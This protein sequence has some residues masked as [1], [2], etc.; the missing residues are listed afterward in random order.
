MDKFELTAENYY[1]NEANKLY[2]SASQYL[3]FVGH[4]GLV[5]CEER[6]VATLNGEWE[7]PT[8]TAQLVGSYVDAYFEG[9]L[10]E[11]TSG[12]PEIFTQKGE[13]RSE[14][15]KAEK[16]IKR[17]EQDAYF[18]STLAGEKQKIFTGYLFG[19][20][21]KVKIDSYL[22]D[23]GIVDLK[24]S[25]D[26]HRLWRVADFGYVC[27]V[28]YWG[29][30]EQL[31]I[32]QKITEINTGKKLPCYIS[33][34]TKEDYPEINVLYIDQASL[35]NALNGIEMNMSNVLAVKNGETEPTR[36]EKC[37]YC[38]STKVLTKAVNF[39][40]LSEWGL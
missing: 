12:H 15:K 2:M 6:A 5:G 31:A 21:W 10:E 4:M 11:L 13:L 1:S 25:S 38:K 32:Y 3:Q 29:Y 37:D 18:M 9:T 40:E 35:N 27:F 24:T 39:N 34:V 23:E 22:P 33:V 28:E 36:C 7:E 26:I 16:M 17:C 19:C 14:Y 8:T 30:L 20:E